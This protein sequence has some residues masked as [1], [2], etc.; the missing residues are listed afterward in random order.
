MGKA[1]GRFCFQPKA[2]QAGRRCQHVPANELQGHD[3]LKA[4]LPRSKN[5]SH[6][7][8]RDLFQQFVVAE[9]EEF[10]GV[11][12]PRV[13][14][15]KSQVRAFAPFWIVANAERQQAPEASAIL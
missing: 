10:Y 15:Q 14:Q 13:G 6:S 11:G 9:R 8:A 1:R 2:S 7:P 4:F 12:R 5:D 3:P